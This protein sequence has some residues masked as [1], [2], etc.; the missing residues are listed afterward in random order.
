MPKDPSF[1]ERCRLLHEAGEQLRTLAEVVALE[2]IRMN[3]AQ[4]RF[5]QRRGLNKQ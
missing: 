3:A 2:A 5:T 1:S 4:K